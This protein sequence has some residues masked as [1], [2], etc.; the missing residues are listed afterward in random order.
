M[1]A[2]RKLEPRDAA[3]VAVEVLKPFN[4]TKAEVAE[5]LGYD[6]V[7]PVKRLMDSGELGYFKRGKSKQAQVRFSREHVADLL[8]R[9]ER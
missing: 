4:N 5:F 3:A 1:T 2:A 6:S 8:R 9:W 7:D